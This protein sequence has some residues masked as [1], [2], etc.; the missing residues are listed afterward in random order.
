M[1][2]LHIFLCSS[3]FV[4]V[5]CGGTWVSE[6]HFHSFCLLNSFVNTSLF[7]DIITKTN[8]NV[9]TQH[10]QDENNPHSVYTL[11]I[12]VIR[13]FHSCLK[14]QAVKCTCTH[15]HPDEFL[16]ENATDWKRE[17]QLQPPKLGG[18][19]PANHDLTKVVI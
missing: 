12:I 15:N 2:S 1:L 11:S 9:Y 4:S 13:C 10:F 7:L 5:T 16:S 3:N 18:H 17:N 8:G 14:V 19:P 6:I